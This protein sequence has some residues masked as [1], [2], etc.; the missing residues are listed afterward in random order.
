MNPCL[1]ISFNDNQKTLVL[2]NEIARMK[3]NEEMKQGL[4]VEPD[5]SA[6][7]TK[8]PIS[9]KV[10]SSISFRTYLHVFRTYLHV[11]RTY[12]LHLS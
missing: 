5:I 3:E 6:H 2:S 12:L 7:A 11:C 8:T 1:L 4:A 9:I 10:K